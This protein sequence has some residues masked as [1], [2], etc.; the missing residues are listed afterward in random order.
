MSNVHVLKLASYEPPV[1]EESKKNEWVTYGENNSYYTFLMQRYKN[2]TT[3][4]AIINN[5]S[6]LIYGK[7]LSATDA[8]KKPNEYAQMKAMISAEDLRKVVLDFEM[9]G[10]AAFQVHYTADRK[11][12]Q[13]LYHI[14]VH[15]LAPEKCNKDGEIEAYYYSNNWEDIRNY[16]P[17]RIPAFGFGN[18]KV[19][20][21]IIQPYSVGMKYF[22]YVDYQG[23][24]PYAVLEEDIS[25]YL[26]NEVN[27][28]FSGRIVV[29]FN[30]GIPTPEEQDI[31]KSK[32]LSQLSGT[33]GHKVIVAFN[34]NSE[35]K[36][37][38]DA[39]PVN[40]APDLYNQLSE[41]CMRKIMLSHNVTSPL[42]FG[43][44]TTTGFS[45]NADE[46]QN[47]FILFDNMVIKPKQEV[48]LEAIDQALAYNN[49]SL[50]LRFEELQPLDAEGDLTKTDEAEKVITAINSLSPLVA[51]KVLESMTPNEI[52]SLV[53]LK[54][55]S[56]GSDIAPI[57]M[58]AEAT[59]E[60]LDILLN[61]LEGE[62]LGDEWERVTEREVKEDNISTEEWVNNALNPK[63]S[64]LA[65]LA[66]IIK[67]EPSRESNLDK[68]VYK[69]RY[70]YSERY[71]KP[72]SRD[73]CVKMMSRT[74][75][76]V[77]YRLEDIDK[78]SRAGVN[79]ELGH[80]GQ[81][82]DLFKFK[83]GVNCSHYWKEVL[84]KLKQKDGK[85]VEDK[86]LSS[87]NEVNSIPKSY[88]PRPTGNA[89]SKVAPIDMPNNG[90]HPNYGK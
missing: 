35:S 61:D 77:V 72:N 32:V 10:Q 90:H 4:N 36:T 17:E 73:F 37:T 52:R 30:N 16:A 13:K 58:S 24:I 3:N 87:S 41:E 53:G 28:G 8:N 84:Y 1:I 34:N 39:M 49:V 50:D 57:Q 71:S 74:N 19:E 51:N 67:S 68:S 6:R 79:K 66:S 63:K 64:V 82:Y 29:N 44:A 27:R 2:S 62:V 83:G 81:A 86:S 31:I 65:K 60:E 54:A 14:P 5:I 38:V 45:A 18:E 47:S 59:D 21:L 76:G 56:G 25:N 20:I 43:I 80:K 22:S 88:Q 9:L 26:I 78:A 70:E 85:Y 75:N 23:G 46:L 48:I 33:D 15:L 42:L 40:D 11:K 7:G 12:V 55:E 89:Q 69:V